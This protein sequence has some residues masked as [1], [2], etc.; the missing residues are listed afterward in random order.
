MPDEYPVFLLLGARG[1]EYLLFG[2]IKNYQ[3]L[4]T[5]ILLVF[6]FPYTCK[7]KLSFPFLHKELEDQQKDAMNEMEHTMENFSGSIDQI[8]GRICELEGSLF[9]NYSVSRKMNNL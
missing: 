8:E 1:I 7:D 4:F 9:E 3:L 5:H 2:P 6:Y